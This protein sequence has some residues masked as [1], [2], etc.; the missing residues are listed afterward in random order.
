MPAPLPWGRG[1]GLPFWAYLLK[2][3]IELIWF[4]GLLEP[5]ERIALR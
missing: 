1:L 2:P 4:R 5:P 3:C